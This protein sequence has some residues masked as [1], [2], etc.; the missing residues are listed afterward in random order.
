MLTADERAGLEEV[1][2]H[3][4]NAQAASVSALKYLQERRG[5]LSDETLADAAG[6]LGL[7]AADLEGLASFYNLLYRQPVGRWVI[8]LCDSVSCWICGYDGIRDHLRQRLGVDYGETTED[9]LF[10]LLPMVCLGDCDHAPVMMVGKDLHRDLTPERVDA[11]LEDYR[12]RAGSDNGEP[13]YD[14]EAGRDNGRPGAEGT[15]PGDADHSDAEPPG[16]RDG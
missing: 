15:D 12:A 14:R 11:I 16:G 1:R 10:T 13:S 6:F 9:G 3:Y 5:W 4:P 8:L 7:P 2:S